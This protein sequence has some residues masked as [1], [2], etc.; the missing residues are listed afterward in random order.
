MEE[1]TVTQLLPT[2]AWA[3]LE[4]DDAA[5][6]YVVARQAVR[7]ARAGT[8]RLTLVDGL[9]VQAM[10]AIRQGW[11]DEAGQALEEGVALAQKVPYPYAEARLLQVCGE[12]HAQKGEPGP[13]RE[14][15]EAALTIFRRLGATKDGEQTERLLDSRS[16]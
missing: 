5:R 11:W 3:H 9:R 2:L 14:R 4:L 1:L 7:R 15:L 12:L 6:A 10:V 8:W 16:T 13:A